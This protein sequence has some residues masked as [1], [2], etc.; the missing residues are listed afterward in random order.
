[1]D[2]TAKSVNKATALKIWSQHTGISL[3]HVVGFGDGDNDLEFL[4]AVGFGVAM[5]NAD[6]Q[7]KDIADREIGHVN[8]DGLGKYLEAII[9]GKAM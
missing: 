1:V 6:Q 9:S 7:L 4:K 2:I 3:D 5:G 8:F